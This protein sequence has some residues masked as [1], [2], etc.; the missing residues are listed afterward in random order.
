[1]VVALRA[2]DGHTQHGFADR[3]HAVEHGFH[4]ELLGV[5]AAF[6][7]GHGV[8]EKAGGDNLIL[9]GAGQ[10]VPGD[11]ID[12]ELVVG[13]VAIERPNHPVTIEPDL[14]RLIFLE[15]VGIGVARGI[16]PNPSPALAVMGRREQPVNLLL[17]GIPALVVEEGVDFFDGGRKADQVQAQ[18][19]QQGD[20]IGFGRGREAL[21]FQAS[22]NEA[23]DRIGGPGGAGDFWQ[24]GTLR[25]D[26][27]PVLL[28]LGG[29]VG[30]GGALIDPVSNKRELRGFERL[31]AHGHARQI[32]DTGHTAIEQ[33]IGRLTRLDDGAG[34]T[35]GEGQLLRIQPQSAHLQLLAMAGIAGAFED[36]LDVLGEIGGAGR[37]GGA[38]C[39]CGQEQQAELVI[40]HSRSRS[41]LRLDYTQAGPKRAE[42]DSVELVYHP[43]LISTPGSACLSFWI[44]SSVTFVCQ[45]Y[46]FR[47]FLRPAN[48]P[49]PAS[50]TAVP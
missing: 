5:H 44:P 30:P 14:S 41:P 50:L 13:Q 29:P 7:V 49:S 47:R 40:S 48:C 3:I 38:Q 19:P 42:R 46:R 15:A 35:A 8:A 22:Q 6:L 10:Q 36:R 21:F 32:A 28:G 43:L 11:L 39:R 1:M 33:A 26:E 27:S 24:R 20:A 9:A 31:T 16:E 23:V 37:G 18:P 12:D 2:L 4:A 17:V 25:R 45:T 34:F